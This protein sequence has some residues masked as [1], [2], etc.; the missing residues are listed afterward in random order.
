[1]RTFYVWNIDYFLNLI[2]VKEGQPISLFPAN[3]TPALNFPFNAHIFPEKTLIVF[4]IFT[5]G[6]ISCPGYFS[7]KSSWCSCF[8]LEKWN[9]VCLMKQFMKRYFIWSHILSVQSV[10]LSTTWCGRCL[11]ILNEFCVTFPNETVFG[12]RRGQ[13]FLI[14]TKTKWFFEWRS[15][16]S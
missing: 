14:F 4:Q 2:K 5:S 12:E 3:D 10:I 1:M 16:E 6:S 7:I 11:N 8:F 15:W 9:W 13:I